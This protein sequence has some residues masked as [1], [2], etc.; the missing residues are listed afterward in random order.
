MDV[1]SWPGVTEYLYQAASSALVLRL[2]TWRVPFGLSPRWSSDDC[3]PM[4]GIAIDTGGERRSDGS[5]RA[6]GPIVPAAAAAGR[7]G[8]PA[9][10]LAAAPKTSSAAPA[11]PA[12]LVLARPHGGGAGANWLSGHD[13][14]TRS[15]P[16]RG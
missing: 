2:G 16:M 10:P 12:S 11:R 7:G 4:A 3:T 9:T 14:T 5:F 6:A 8:G 15:P 13:M 1:P